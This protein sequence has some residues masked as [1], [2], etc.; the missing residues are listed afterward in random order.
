MGFD[1][2]PRSR[3]RLFDYIFFLVVIA[4]LVGFFIWYQGRNSP[5]GEGEGGSSTSRERREGDSEEQPGDRRDSR[6]PA[7]PGDILFYYE[8]SAKKWLESAI[9]DFNEEHQGRWRVVLEAYGSRDGKQNILYGRGRPVIWNP[10]DAYWPD[11]LEMDWRNP[12]VGGH[13][14]NVIRRTEIILTTRLTLLMWEDRAQAFRAAMRLPEYRGKTWKL[15]YDLATKG[16][17]SIGAPPSWG[18]LKLMQSNPVESNSGM[19]ALALMFREYRGE[20]A[21]MRPSEPGFLRFMRNIQDTVVAFDSTT[22]K[23]MDSF[24]RGGPQQADIAVVYEANAI[25]ALD[26]GETSVRVIYPE[27][28]VNVEFPAAILQGDWVTSRQ[29]EGAN[30]LVDYLL[31]PKVQRRAMEQSGLRP[32]LPELRGE[33][34]NA[35]SSGSRADKGL[36]LDVQTVVRPVSTRI[37]DELLYQW[38]K[39]YGDR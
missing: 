38:H 29:T 39:S 1:S 13:T 25:S 12:R 37:V 4:G 5:S 35:L 14:S 9:S 20:N 8:R 18:K 23:T 11:K 26:R 34:D 16:W 33:V 6:A 10:A 2:S 7:E 27:P 30:A 32:V 17:S 28:T 19:T 3:T 15:L 21:S 24:L 31:Q 22:S 36:A